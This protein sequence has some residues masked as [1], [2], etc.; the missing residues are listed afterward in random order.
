MNKYL[1]HGKL[2]AAPGKRDELK[3]ILLRAAEMVRPMDG[4]S[5]YAVSIG[6]GE[7]DVWVTEVWDS[8]EKHNDSLQNDEVKNLIGEAMPLIAVPPTQGQ[9]LTVVGGVA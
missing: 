7:N 6:D 2:T 1:S 9:E 4:C 5:L 3:D 8:K